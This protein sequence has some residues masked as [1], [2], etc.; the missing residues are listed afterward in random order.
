[1]EVAV[2]IKVA[3]R[4]L[5][6][7]VTEVEPLGSQLR[8]RLVCVGGDLAGLE[9]DVLY[10]TETLSILRTDPDPDEAASL[11]DWRRY[12]I[13]RLLEQIPGAPVPMGRVTIEAFQRVPLLR[14]LDMVRPRLL[15]ADGVGLGKTI[16]AG[17]IAAELLIR[18]RVHRILIV[19]PPGPLLC[20]W[21]QEMRL[22]FGLRFTMITD[23]LSLRQARQGLELGGNLFDAT[24]LCLTSVD[25]AKRDEVL[26]ELERVSW[27]LVIID[28]AHHCVGED[29][30]RAR[31]A[32]VLSRRSD[33]LLLL[34]AT[35]HDGRDTHFAALM[36][37]LDPSLVDGA[38]RLIGTSYR[39][40]VIRR[41][42]SHLLT[43]EGAPL[44]RERVVTPVRVDV[45]GLPTVQAFHRALSALVAP[46]LQKPRDRTD[47]TDALAFVSL[48]K[49]SMSTIAACLATLRVVAERYGTKPQRERRRALRAH[50]RR[51]ATFG[52]LAAAEEAEIADLEAE[53]IAA[54]LADAHADLC[55]LIGLGEAAA[56][57]DP[58]LSA[59]LLE[60]RLIRLQHP[61]ANILVYTEYTDS[62]QAA[63]RALAGID[64]TLLTISGADGEAERS[65]A[66]ER[67]AEEDGIVLI[68]TDSLAEG[69]NLHQRCFH[70]IHLDLPYN[71]NRLEQRNGRIDRYG[72]KHDPQIRYLFLAGTF[73]E[74]LL[75]RLIAKYEKARACLS[76][77]P[78]TLGVGADPA[79]LHEP[80]FLGFAEDLF[81]S[82]PRLVHSLD[83]AAEDTDSDAYRELLRE[84]DRGFQSFDHMAVR[85]GW[86]SGGETGDFPRLSNVSG[87]DLAAFVKSTLVPEGDAYRVPTQWLADLAG[88]P[89]VDVN[90]QQVRLADHPDQLRDPSGRPL[91][92]PGRTHPLTRRAI[93]SVRTGRVSAAQGSTL[94]LLVTYVV[95]AALMLRHVFAL[96]LSP[97]GLVAEQDDILAFAGRAICP[98]GLWQKL[99]ADW[100]PA[101]ME[102]AAQHAAEVGKRVAAASSSA[103]YN[104]N[105][106]A[107]AAAQ[108]WLARRSQEL[109]GPLV[110]VFDDL[111]D[112]R[113]LPATWQS[114]PVPEQRLAEFAADPAIAP[115][116][117]REAAEAVARMQAL[118]AGQPPFPRH[119]IRPLGLL[120]LVP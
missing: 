97:N 57:H 38:G 120:M 94:G 103:H 72:Q 106:Q 88:L 105:E 100:A 8:V 28:E 9:W 24:A 53:E 4:G 74:R 87:I 18:R 84:I 66:A 80:L 10:P 73:E 81:S 5:E 90:H 76:F 13:A 44:F 48:L 67:C 11:L 85:H 40:H 32:G 101:A 82:M 7:D 30:Q 99:F 41:L 50:H 78:N 20:Q 117:R 60:I 3:A 69:L 31:L 51:V 114:C 98:D 89:G 52:V 33:G 34:T 43:P 16:Q 115:G 23:S 45:T 119:V 108:A 58:K 46:R 54:S 110:S 61:N 26:A 42:K 19:C 2:G 49:R 96:H 59:L 75:L 64:G 1:M 77:M 56:A 112:A 109:C 62:Q 111:F 104:R 22:R 39:R 91:A 107:A 12:H 15:L 86:L 92:Y 55:A 102:A 37:L 29:N 35:P 47:L 63:V 36:A 83:L 14:A 68:S 17:L 6:W 65:R 70:L 116:P 113:A 27:D 21:E 93:A 118:R 79:R 95:E 25:F 71:P